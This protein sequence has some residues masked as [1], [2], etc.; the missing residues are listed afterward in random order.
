MARHNSGYKTAL[1]VGFSK[2]IVA[3][4]KMSTLFIEANTTEEPQ[5]SQ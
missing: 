2:G 1:G 5:R 3:D 4:Y